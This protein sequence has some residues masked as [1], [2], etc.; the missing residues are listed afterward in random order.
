VFRILDHIRPTATGLD[1]IPAWFLRLGA[2]V[3][4]GPIAQ[5]FNQAITA[6]TVPSQWKAAIITPVPKVSKPS[7]PS[8]FR[9]IS[10]TPVLS[11]SFEK[12]IVRSYIYPALQEPPSGLYFADQFAFRPTGSTTA[13]IVAIFHTILTMLSSNA[14]VRVL[15]LDFSKAFDTIRHATLM[16]KMA[17]LKLPD[18]IFNWIK[19]FFDGRS[20]CTKY[21]GEVSTCA[22][23]QASVIQGSGLGPATYLVTASDLR[24]VH[25]DNQIVKFADDTYLIIPAVNS[26][27]CVAE[28]A[29]IK[30]WAKN[31]NLRLNCAKT[32]E[33]VFRPK[34]KRGH[35]TQIPPPCEGIERVSSLTVLGVVIND[36]M[37]AADH[38][39][40]LLT[41]CSRLLYALRVLRHH[42]IQAASMN[43]IF[44]STVLAKLTY[45]SPAWSGFCSATDRARLESFLRRCQRLGYCD[46]DILTLSE[47]FHN[48]DDQLFRRILNNKA[49]TLQLYLPDKPHCQY[50][51]RTTSHNKELI[52]KTTELNSRDFFIR[53]LYKNC[54]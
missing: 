7:Q 43:D 11:R 28:L 40:G 21:A 2:P 1:D 25:S 52:A 15:A 41:S 33:I 42:G 3:F 14:F 53:M 26:D 30:Q 37:T 22:S 8:D 50:N 18:Q 24:P 23:I 54:Y 34:A 9:P 4:A 31:N 48:A 45:C 51:L 29:H 35:T 13:A 38:V 47:M 5:L 39:S 44:R 27:S 46:R 6:G 17:Q 20:H 49:H 16:E 32:K 36:Q 12:Y 10:I 19:D